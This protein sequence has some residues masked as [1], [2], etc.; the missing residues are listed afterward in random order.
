[1]VALAP[2]ELVRIAE[3]ARARLIRDLPARALRPGLLMSS[4]GSWSFP[5]SRSASLHEH[6]SDDRGWIGND[7]L[8][9]LA[10]QS[11]Q[12][13]VLGFQDLGLVL[14]HTC[15]NEVEAFDHHAPEERS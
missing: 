11:A 6:L 9:E 10:S 1:M 7:L 12:N 3:T 5:R 15:L 8:S 14:S 4:L 13:A 2:S